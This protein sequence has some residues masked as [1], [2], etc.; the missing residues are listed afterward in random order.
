MAAM[1]RDVR[2]LLMRPHLGSDLC[3]IVLNSNFEEIVAGW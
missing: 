2:W 1:A 3:V